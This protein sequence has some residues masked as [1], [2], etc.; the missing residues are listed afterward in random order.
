MTLVEPFTIE[1]IDY[2][3]SWHPYRAE[4]TI[5]WSA[6]QAREAHASGRPY[7]ALLYSNGLYPWSAVE[8]RRGNGESYIDVSFLS[9]TGHRDVVYFFSSQRD[10]QI[11]FLR[12]ALFFSNGNSQ[13]DRTDYTW[14]LR[15]VFTVTGSASTRFTRVVPSLRTG[16]ANWTF[17]VSTHWEPFPEFGQYSSLAR[18]DRGQSWS[19]ADD[20]GA[21]GTERSK[22]G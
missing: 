16:N 1:R 4:P 17:D 22:L 14:R 15:H 13:T 20:H 10:E 9:S 19:V 12:S 5:A 11:L 2:C 3:N 21:A 6:T 18:V 7:G 8:I